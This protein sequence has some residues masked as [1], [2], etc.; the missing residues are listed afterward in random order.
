MEKTMICITIYS[1]DGIK[2]R[3]YESDMYN[4]YLNT[5]NKSCFNSCAEYGKRRKE[6]IWMNY[7]DKQLSFADFPEILP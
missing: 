6:V 7:S 5:W 1:R 2:F 3:R 4:D